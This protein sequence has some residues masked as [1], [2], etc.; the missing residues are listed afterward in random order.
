MFRDDDKMRTSDSIIEFEHKDDGRYKVRKVQGPSRRKQRNFIHSIRRRFCVYYHSSG[1]LSGVIRLG[2]DKYINEG[3]YTRPGSLNGD[4]LF[5]TYFTN[6][7][8]IF[9]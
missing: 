1:I 4:C 7:T 2:D 5:R 6:K 8:S 3:T 9:F